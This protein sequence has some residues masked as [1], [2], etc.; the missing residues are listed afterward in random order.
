MDSWVTASAA[1]RGAGGGGGG[2]TRWSRDVGWD[3]GGVS[4]VKTGRSRSGNGGDRYHINGCPHWSSGGV[5]PSLLSLHDNGVSSPCEYPSGRA[6]ALRILHPLSPPPPR[7]KTSS[8]L[9]FHGFSIGPHRSSSSYG[10]TNSSS[11]R[12]R[13]VWR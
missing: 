4:E 8:T 13:K 5:P 1:R 3:V 10:S 11:G 2:R 9:H 7:R 12:E 6:R